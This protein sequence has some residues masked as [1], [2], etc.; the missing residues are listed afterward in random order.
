[1]EVA[2]QYD[3]FF[4]LLIM[5]LIWFFN[6]LMLV[7]AWKTC[8]LK[9]INRYFLTSMTVADLLIGIFIVPFS[10]WTSLF[11]EWVFN[12]KFCHVEAYLNA[13]LW[14]VSLYSYMCLC[15]DHF[16]GIRKPQRHEAELSPLRCFC[17]VTLIWIS[18]LCFCCPLMFGENRGRYEDNTHLCVIDWSSQRAY[19]ITSGVVITVPALVVITFTNLYIFTDDYKNRKEVYEKFFTWNRGG[20]PENYFAAFVIGL[21]YLFS[22]LPWCIVELFDHF[23]IL[24]YDKYPQQMDFFL[25]W[26]V[27][28][29]SFFKLPVFLLCSQEFRDGLKY[30]WY[31]VKMA[32]RSSIEITTA[33]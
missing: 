7:I 29:N 30:V 15:I 11:S 31:N 3:S 16:V 17:W 4:I 20:R 14:I 21:V 1:M 19:F 24:G 27:V 12:D 32:C 5:F 26:L 28:S 33:I 22:W 10:F 8:A 13:I 25:L 23:K 2:F 6:I 18:A 9:S